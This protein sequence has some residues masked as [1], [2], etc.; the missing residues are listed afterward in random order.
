MEKGTDIVADKY[1]DKTVKPRVAVKWYQIGL[2]L[3]MESFKLDNIRRV[4]DRITEQC[5][6]MLSEWLNRSSKE[7]ES[8]R[9]TWENMHNAMTALNLN[10]GAERLEE[11]LVLE[12]I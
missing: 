2:K 7:P 6:E 5:L 10:A 8:F 11:K 1:L 3:N 4:T 12:D 9:P